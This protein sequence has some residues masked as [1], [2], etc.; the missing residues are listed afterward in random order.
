M[1]ENP[2]F[3]VLNSQIA[4]L[5]NTKF[6][7]TKYCTETMVTMVKLCKSSDCLLVCDVFA[8][9][10]PSCVLSVQCFTGRPTL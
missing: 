10:A 3:V 1:I 9:S 4:V 8:F 5:A 2:D 6:T 7:K